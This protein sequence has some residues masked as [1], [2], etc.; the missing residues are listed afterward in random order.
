MLISAKEALSQQERKSHHAEIRHNNKVD[1]VATPKKRIQNREMDLVAGKEN[2]SFDRK[3]SY[4]GIFI[5][6]CHK[7]GL[8]SLKR[9][10]SGGYF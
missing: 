2:H 1:L 8:F 3:F 6:F 5:S 4:R 10:S 7:G 9:S